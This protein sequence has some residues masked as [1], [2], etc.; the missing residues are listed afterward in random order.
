MGFE[1]K[2]ALV[3]G[4]GTGIGKGIAVALGRQGAKVAVNYVVD[5]AAAEDTVRQ[6]VDAGGEATSVLADVSLPEQVANMVGLV[7][8]VYGGIDILVNNA[9]RQP[10]LSLLEYDEATYDAVMAVNCMGY[11]LMI[12]AVVPSMKARGGGRIINISSVHGKRPTDFDV[13]YAM[14]KGGIKML[15]REAAIELARYQ[16]T[17]NV[18]E[19]GAV[20]VGA[21]SGNPRP[22]VPPGLAPEI[23]RQD[24][25]S[26]FPLGRVGQPEDIAHVVAF[27]A[28][29]ESEYITGAAIRADGGS[30]L[31]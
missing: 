6:I 19:P 3:T 12:Q 11:W 4:A 5:P 27:L 24:A 21:K 15:S 18:I 10:N 17:V 14:S 8:D 2:V 1:G 22:I 31:L 16:I 30:M 25:H 9:A 28:S 26:K 7:V 20:R 13:V 23:R 29:A